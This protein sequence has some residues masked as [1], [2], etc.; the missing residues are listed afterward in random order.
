MSEFDK[1]FNNIEIKIP[2]K[3]LSYF[4]DLVVDAVINISSGEEFNKDG[5]LFWIFLENVKFKG[6]Y[7][8]TDYCDKLAV[9]IAHY[10]SY[11]EW[12][13]WREGVYKDEFFR[14][15]AMEFAESAFE[16]RNLYKNRKKI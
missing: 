5:H 9:K 11:G 6:V 12:R 1:C 7:S 15:L 2:E 10:A 14:E 8:F 4:I 16:A 13:K 3:I